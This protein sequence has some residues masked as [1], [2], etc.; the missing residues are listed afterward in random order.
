[1]IELRDIYCLRIGT[2]DLDKAEY[3]ATEIVGLQTVL[4][5]DDR[6]YLRSDKKHHSLCYIKGDPKDHTVAF[7]LKDW[8]GLD[9][10][11]AQLDAAGI[12]CGRGSADEA[13]DRFTH[14][15]GWFH[16]PTGNRI[17]IWVR[18]HDANRIYHPKRL[19]GITGFGHIG[20]NTTDPV[21]DQDFWLE[22]FNAKISDWIGPAPLMRVKPQH[23]QFALFP[24]KGPGIQH[25]NHQVESIDD[26]MR[27][28]YFLQKQGVK[29]VFGPGRHAT[30]GG[31]FLY[32]E[33][34]DGL[35]FEYSTS[36][37]MIIE[38]DENYRPRQFALEDES[39]CIFGAKPDIAEFKR[40][41][42][43][44][45]PKVTPLFG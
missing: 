18:P 38:D 13:E 26:L 12:E 15:F 40:S 45:T 16:D 14:E 20:L 5:T 44:E 7:E 27:A 37:R 9:S 39:F 23:H 43:E 33:G 11:L 36:D 1:M 30:S 31:Y 6:L 25:V 41:D 29:I 3:F 28:A 17:E 19:T 2:S 24:T 22:H 35:T 8:R 10:A 4:R 21:R 34:L 42:E 32:F